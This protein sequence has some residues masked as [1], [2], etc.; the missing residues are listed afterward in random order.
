MPLPLR[1]LH[2]LE[3]L[4]TDQRRMPATVL[5]NEG[6]MLRLLLD[7]GERGLL[8]GYVG[9]GQTWFSEAQLRACEGNP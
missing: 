2:C 6:W 1:L 8:P 7:A 3:Q 9:P 5:Y 4:A